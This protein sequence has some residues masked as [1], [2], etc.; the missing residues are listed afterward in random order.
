MIGVS[1]S[2]FGSLVRYKIPCLPFYILFLAILYHIQLEKK[3]TVPVTIK[4]KA[5]VG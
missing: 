5:T 3:R 4:A 2:N 1:S